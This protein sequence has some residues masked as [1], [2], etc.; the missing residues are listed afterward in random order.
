MAAWA[1]ADSREE[2]EW[3]SHPMGTMRTTP[4]PGRRSLGWEGVNIVPESLTTSSSRGR[5]KSWKV[6]LSLAAYHTEE[7]KIYNHS[8]PKLP[9]K[10]FLITW[11]AV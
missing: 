11:A 3:H 6:W 2:L 7:L 10:G 9:E 5:E 4:S 1:G 8:S